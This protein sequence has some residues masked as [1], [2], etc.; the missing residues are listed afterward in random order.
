MSEMTAE[1]N[2]A[3]KTKPRDNFGEECVDR[4][5][6]RGGHRG[7]RTMRQRRVL[8]VHCCPGIE[9]APPLVQELEFSVSKMMV[10][11][12][13]CDPWHWN[14]CDLY[15]WGGCD[16]KSVHAGPCPRAKWVGCHPSYRA[17]GIPRQRSPEVCENHLWLY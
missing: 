15:V 16:Y 8:Y 2:W 14:S 7:F 13:E 12:R 6:D 4:G 11:H 3:L 10:M 17:Q 1:S 9:M 5:P